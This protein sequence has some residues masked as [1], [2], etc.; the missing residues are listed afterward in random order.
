VL[1]RLDL[2][3]H[4]G[5]D[6]EQVEQVAAGQEFKR[7]IFGELERCSAEAGGRPW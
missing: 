5:M 3:V 4:I 2:G 7:L 1:R 6:L